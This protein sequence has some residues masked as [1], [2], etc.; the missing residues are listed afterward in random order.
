MGRMF[1]PDSRLMRILSVTASFLALNLLWLLCCVP[2]VTAGTA[3]S[4]M[5]AV[6]RK[7]AR[8]EDPSVAPE[9]FA[10]FRRNF[11]QGFPA[12]LILLLPTLLAAVYLVL[13]TS[14]TLTSAAWFRPLCWIAI[15]IIAVICSY[16]WP[17]IAW[18][19]NSL[20]NIFK[21][22]MLLPVSNPLIALGVTVLNLVP[23]FLLLRDAEFFVRISFFWV[24]AG[25]ALTAFV[26]T[27]LLRFQLRGFLPEDE[28]VRPERD[29]PHYDDTEE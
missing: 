19:E 10:A 16:V 8:R 13:S 6:T 23:V 28:F 17:Q 4:A 2:V 21:N 1:H 5:Y 29:E 14:E 20:G 3:T 11:R 26:N 12:T 18:F 7:M 24:V 22:A 25:G 15:F 9:F 27:Q